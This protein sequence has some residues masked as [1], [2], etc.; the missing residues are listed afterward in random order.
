MAVKTNIFDLGK[1]ELNQLLGTWGEPS[2][3]TTQI[4][5]G[6]YHN[7]FES[8]E[9]FTALSNRL[10]E[11]LKSSFSFQSLSTSK[12][13]ISEDGQTRKVMF[14]LPD[15]QAIET[16]IMQT[17]HRNTVCVST[18]IGC[19]M[20]CVFCAT[21]QMGYKRNLTRGEIIEQ[22]IISAREL[23]TVGKH[24]TNVVF[25]GM[26]EPLLNYDE[27]M[28]A[29]ACLHDEDGFNLGARNFTLS[30]V[31]IIPGIRRFTYEHD[32]VNLSISLH[33]S[34]NKLRSELVPINKK[35]PLEKL[36]ETCHNY[37]LNTR[38][39]ITFE[40]ALIQDINDTPEQARQLTALLHGMLCHVN[41]ILLNPTSKYSGNASSQNRAIE[42]IAIL[43]K[44][45]IPCT[46]RI[47]RGVDIQAGC[48]QLITNRSKV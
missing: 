34:D 23:N 3:R 30:T 33:A 29:I 39:R 24:I 19:G 8:P 22:V 48:G 13:L 44:K 21:G 45:G 11:Q 31:G 16:V 17:K 26:G 47:R 1:V 7:R 9:K 36:I 42:F 6:L 14:D 38:R 46:L 28:A 2:F 37:I 4:W 12:E 32:Q 35:Y 40:W 10:R 25:M 18:Q 27:V 15:N 20:G 5:Q 43:D 41:L